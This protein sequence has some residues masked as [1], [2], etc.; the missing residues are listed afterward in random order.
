MTPFPFAFTPIEQV[1]IEA[2]CEKRPAVAA[3]AER[4]ALTLDDLARTAVE[5]SLEGID[6]EALGGSSMRSRWRVALVERGRQGERA[7]W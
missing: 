3:V 1:A 7:E 2:I 4:P 5:R 6:V